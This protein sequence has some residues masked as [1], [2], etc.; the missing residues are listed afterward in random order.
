MISVQSARCP[1]IFD[2]EHLFRRQPKSISFMQQYWLTFF[3][4]LAEPEPTAILTTVDKV[5]LAVFI[6]DFGML[7]A[8]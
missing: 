5:K 3:S 1:D 6:Q 7:H 2:H 8:D 4:L